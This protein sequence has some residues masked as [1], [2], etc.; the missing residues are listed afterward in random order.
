MSP[1]QAH[2]ISRTFPTILVESSHPSFWAVSI[3][4]AAVVVQEKL[5]LS[6]G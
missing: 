5:R 4:G 2:R 1:E 6:E 3:A